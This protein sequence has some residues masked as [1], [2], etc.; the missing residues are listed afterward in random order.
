MANT[1]PALRMAVRQNDRTSKPTRAGG[2]GALAPEKAAREHTAKVAK[3]PQANH[4]DTHKLFDPYFVPAN[5]AQ[6][7][8]TPESEH[9]RLLDTVIACTLPPVHSGLE[10]VG[11]AV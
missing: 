6:P 4:L 10:A 2:L 7:S 5:L 8:R 1:H 9:A 3:G 11:Q